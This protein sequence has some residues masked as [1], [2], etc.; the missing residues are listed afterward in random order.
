[1]KIHVSLFKF[2]FTLSTLSCCKDR[3]SKISV[4][5]T[6]YPYFIVITKKL[7]TIG[8]EMPDSVGR[9][10]QRQRFPKRDLEISKLRQAIKW[11]RVF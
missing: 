10:N 5:K 7:S 1:M 4:A 11:L 9:R 6:Q 8:F 2:K 3:D